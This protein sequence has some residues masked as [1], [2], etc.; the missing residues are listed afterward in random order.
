[1]L[2]V[3]VTPAYVVPYVQFLYASTTKISITLPRLLRYYIP[4]CLTIYGIRRHYITV[5]QKCSS[6]KYLYVK[7]D[8]VRVFGKRH[9]QLRSKFYMLSWVLELYNAL[10]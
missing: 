5:M 7:L 4:F 9:V 2:L 8:T 3:N 1:M 6:L 10:I